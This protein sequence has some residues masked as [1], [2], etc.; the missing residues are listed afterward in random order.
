MIWLS[1]GTQEYIEKELNFFMIVQSPYKDPIS[2]VIL[3]YGEVKVGYKCLS[4]PN[5][6][7][8][9]EYLYSL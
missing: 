4:S 5:V 3:T 2:S 6:V 8:C 7:Q 9:P 1:V